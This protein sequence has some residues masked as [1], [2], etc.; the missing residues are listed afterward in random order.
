MLSPG[1][2]AS[3]N[4]AFFA[5]SPT[6]GRAVYLEVTPPNDYL[7]FALPIPYSLGKYILHG[8][9]YVTAMAY[10]TPGCRRHDNPATGR[11]PLIASGA[12][13]GLDQVLLTPA[14]GACLEAFAG[15]RR[16]RYSGACLQCLHHRRAE[17]LRHRPRHGA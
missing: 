4:V 5:S 3:A 15:P 11:Q 12:A 10:H 7:H 1:E 8:D 17:A 14:R 16:D 13:C 2:T 9:L 6:P